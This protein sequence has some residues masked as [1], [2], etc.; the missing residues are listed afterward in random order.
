MTKSWI[1]L[2]AAIVAEVA[3]TSA[4]NASDGFSRKLPAAAALGGYAIAFYFLSL[5]LRD[6]DVG[7]A[8]AI[9]S[10][11]GICILALIGHVW[12]GQSLSPRQLAGIGLIIGGVI[13]VQG[14]AA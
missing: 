1:C 10:G 7:V 4:L 5:A 6:I 12:L 9:W 13:L 14:S 2:A 3:A 8:Y 11:I